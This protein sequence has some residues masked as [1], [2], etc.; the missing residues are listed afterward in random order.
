MLKVI[1]L[2]I[3]IFDKAF[4]AFTSMTLSAKAGSALKV[5]WIFQ[6]NNIHLLLEKSRAGHAAFGLGR[7]MSAGDIVVVETTGGVLKVT[8]CRLSGQVTPPC[9]ESQDWTIVDQQ[10]TSSSFKIEIMRPVRTSDPHDIVYTET[11]TPVIYAYSDDANLVGHTGAGV[12]YSSF[13]LDFKTGASTP[14]GPRL[15]DGTWMLHEHTQVFLWTVVVDILV[16]VG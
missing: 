11:S 13:N 12:E 16:P 7:S 6:N 5:S 4:C 2:A 3:V 15:G 8:D 9:S 1:L 14:L 10:L